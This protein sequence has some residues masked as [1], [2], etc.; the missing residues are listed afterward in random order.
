VHFVSWI[1][2]AGNGHTIRVELLKDAL[3]LIEWLEG[4]KAIN[5]KHVF[6]E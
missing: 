4:C 3:K 6:E 2:H 1:D 5:I